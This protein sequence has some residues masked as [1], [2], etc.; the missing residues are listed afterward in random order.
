MKVAVLGGGISG[1]SAAY[2]AKK[3]GAEVTLFEKEER[4]G[5]WVDTMTDPYF[6]EKGP[7]TFKISRSLALLDLIFE[8]GLKE[9][10]IVSDEAAKVRYL[11]LDGKLQRFPKPIFSWQVLKGILREWSVAPFSGDESIGD[12]ATRRFNR[13]VADRLFDPLAMGV[14]AGDIYQ[15]SIESCFPFFKQLEREYGS[16]IKG[17]I[18]RKKVKKPLPI[19]GELFT[20]KGGAKALI[21]RLSSEVSVRCSTEVT[22]LK[23]GA[24]ET[25]EGSELFDAVICTLPPKQ[26]SRL[27]AVKM[28]EIPMGSIDVLHLGFNQNVLP[29]KG[30]GYLVP[31]C[32]K[33]QV[34]GCIFDSLIFPQQNHSK[35]ETR[36]T[37]MA[38]PG[39][40]SI[41]PILKEL[42]EQIGL[43]A[44]PD[45]QLLHHLVE[46][47]PQYRV[48]HAEQIAALKAQLPSWCLLAGN[49]LAGASVNGC[50]VSGKVAANSLPLPL[51]TP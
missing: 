19:E 5:G 9:Q 10:I 3:N 33:K 17:M 4:L 16:V 37:V 28:P 32:E 12:F 38:R 20:L 24:I 43:T 21:E 1:L 2:Y 25:A 47:I 8:L 44:R 41:E 42:E 36:L 27:L 46:A 40:S 13:A 45:F 49:Y 29:I 48:G 51:S 26:L 34:M 14:F 30:F 22:G 39:Q 18:R 35:K 6:F 11:F 31:T 15:L 50:V 7:R 23:E